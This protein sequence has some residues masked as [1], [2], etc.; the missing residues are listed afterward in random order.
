MIL[1]CHR[2]APCD[3]HSHLL[4]ALTVSTGNNSLKKF[5]WKLKQSSFFVSLVSS[6]VSGRQYTKI[7]CPLPV[8]NFFREATIFFQDRLYFRPYRRYYSEIRRWAFIVAHFGEKFFAKKRW[9]CR[10]YF[11]RSNVN[12]ENNIPEEW[13]K[14]PRVITV[15]HYSIWCTFKNLIQQFCGWSF[16]LKQVVF[17]WK[18]DHYV[19]YMLSFC[20]LNRIVF[21]EDWTSKF[22]KIQPIF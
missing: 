18:T 8:S 21:T 9:Q 19:E 17:A 15:K 3:C 5:F 1:T 11:R 16:V 13:N 14:F 4:T 20:E 2:G 7:A 12:F 6:E 22:F 10:L